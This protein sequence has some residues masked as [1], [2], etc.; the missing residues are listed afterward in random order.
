MKVEDCETIDLMGG[1][2]DVMNRCFKTLDYVFLETITE[3][4][5]VL[6]GTKNPYCQEL[7]FWHPKRDLIR[8]FQMWPLVNAKINA[9]ISPKQVQQEMF[10]LAGIPFEKQKNRCE[11]A[12]AN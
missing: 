9:G 7:F 8:I 2:G 6:L 4:V 12:H 3:P 11:S 5:N 10:E 1:L